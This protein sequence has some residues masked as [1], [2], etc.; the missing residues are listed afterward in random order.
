M[1]RGNTVMDDI[2]APVVKT[3]GMPGLSIPPGNRQQGIPVLCE[4]L[5]QLVNRAG[6]AALTAPMRAG[7]TAQKIA[8]TLLLALIPLQIFSQQKESK[9]FGSTLNQSPM[10]H[11]GAHSEDRRPSSH[12]HLIAHTPLV[13]GTGNVSFLKSYQEEPPEDV[14]LGPEQYL[15]SPREAIR[16]LF[17][18]DLTITNDTIYL[19]RSDAAALTERLHRPL[20][21]SSVIVHRISRNTTLR[22]YA[23]VT[24]EH[25]KYRPITLMV[26]V[27]PDFTVHGVRILIYRENR[28]GEVRRKRFLYQ[29]RGK[30]SDDPIRINR[31]II[32]IS[33]AT[34]SVR[35][36]NAGV[37]KILAILE[38]FYGSGV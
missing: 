16:D 31:D 13:T 32:N 12:P 23:V 22:G 9:K 19:S 38:L 30:D 2:P 36:V 33:G 28:G 24:D 18:T 25:G 4:I 27:N 15:M 8:L 11:R 14:D 3:I 26:G 34:I 20:R 6:V 35:G 10:T 1:L 7:G 5:G 17:G 37:R 29:Y 21:D